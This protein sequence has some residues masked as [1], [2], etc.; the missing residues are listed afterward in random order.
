MRRYLWAL[1]LILALSRSAAAEDL[2]VMVDVF[3]ASEEP[4]GISPELEYLSA[5]LQATPFRFNSYRAL[6]TASTEIPVGSEAVLTFDI[7]EPLKVAIR[8][9][10]I[11]SDASSVSVGLSRGE[12]RFLD[13]ELE[14]GRNGTVLVGGPP[15]GSGYLMIAISERW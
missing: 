7:G 8:V 9:R 12:N 15:Y 2:P 11:G 3:T 13:S 14:L 6:G 4:G 10:S 5:R 1:G